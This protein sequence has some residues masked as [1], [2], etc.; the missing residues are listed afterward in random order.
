MTKELPDVTRR[1]T[2]MLNTCWLQAGIKELEFAQYKATGNGIALSAEHMMMAALH[3]RF[4]R[5]I[6]GAKIRSAELESGGEMNEVRQLARIYGVMPEKTWSQPANNW[7]EIAKKLNSIGAFYR[8]KFSDHNK[9]GRDTKP[10]IAEA[11]KE[12]QLVLASFNVHQPKWFMAGGEKTTP[13]E[14]ARKFAIE[15]PEDY[16]ILLP[17]PQYPQKP[18][19]DYLETVQDGFLTSWENIENSIVYE[20]S[21]K[22]SVLLS[23]HWSDKGIKLTNGIMRVVEKPLSGRLE[24]HVVNIVGYHLNEQGRLDR[25]KIENT[26]GRYTGSSGFYSVSWDDLKEMFIGISIPDGFN[27]VKSQQ[28]RGEKVLD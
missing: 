27:F 11:E 10:L 9:R 6:Q 16:I 19:K 13:L 20:I 14:F 7:D 1:L 17:K 3:E 8:Q 23:I 15:V 5:I 2:N 26:W 25:L 24:G 18:T 12:Y 4:F 21:K 22:R 28:M